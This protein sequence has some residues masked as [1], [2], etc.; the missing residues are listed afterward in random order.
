MYSADSRETRPV[1]SDIIANNQRVFSFS[2]VV[3]DLTPFHSLIG[4]FSFPLHSQHVLTLKPCGDEPTFSS[5]CSVFTSRCRPATF[6]PMRISR[7]PRS[8][9]VSLQCDSLAIRTIVLLR[10]AF[11]RRAWLSFL[12]IARSARRDSPWIVADVATASSYHPAN[13][14]TTRPHL[15][16]SL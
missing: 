15:F 12:A 1:A 8:L 3:P 4:T 7:A 11:L 13:T 9:P 2:P 6:T 14:T 16:L 10:R 5:C